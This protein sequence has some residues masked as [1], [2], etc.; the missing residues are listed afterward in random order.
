VLRELEAARQRWPGDSAREYAAR[1]V[2]WKLVKLPRL[3]GG[4][5]RALYDLAS[6]PQETI[7]VAARFPA[8]LEQLERALAAFMDSAQA[9]QREARAPD[10]TTQ[11][12]LR[13]LGY[14]E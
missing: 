7:D 3:E 14:V 13:A 11:E 4:Y 6:D 10:R 8:E 1:G 9:A 2:R 5:R 12:S